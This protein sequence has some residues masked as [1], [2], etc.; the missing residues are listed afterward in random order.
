MFHIGDGR[1][2]VLRY[3]PISLVEVVPR[4]QVLLCLDCHS[5]NLPV[6]TLDIGMLPNRDTRCEPHPSR[7][8]PFQF[9]SPS[10]FSVHMDSS[11]QANLLPITISGKYHY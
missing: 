1:I 11:K 3:P 7:C 9:Q 10:R 5:N 8:L 6:I 4:P 2:E